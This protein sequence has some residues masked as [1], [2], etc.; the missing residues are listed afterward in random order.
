[1]TLQNNQGYRR[2]LNLRETPND[3]VALS[4]LGGAGIGEDLSRLQ[5][6]LRNTSK[7]SFHNIEEGYFSFGDDINV[8]ISSLRCLQSIRTSSTGAVENVTTITVHSSRSYLLRIGDLIKIE[9]VTGTGKITDGEGNLTETDTT[10]GVDI[11]KG[12]FSIT[13]INRDENQF[14]C[15]KAGF[16][17]S[18][19]DQ[20]VSGSNLIIRGRDVFAYT[21]DDTISFDKDVRV[22]VTQGTG[23]PPTII[24]DVTFTKGTP[25][26]V[27]DSNGLD[28]FKLSIRP[29]FDALGISTVV[30]KHGGSD[31][32]YTGLTTSFSLSEDFSM[33][34]S[35]PVEQSNLI[36]FIAPDIQ[37]EGF[38]Y[39]SGT[40][41]E[42]MDSVQTSNETSQYFI[43][44]K[45]KGSSGTTS[46]DQIKTEGSIVLRDP[47][48]DMTS[49]NVVTSYST[50]AGMFIEGTR[51]FSTDNNP[52]SD[53][54]SNTTPNSLE[55][56]SDEVTIGE[57][58]FGNPD[59]PPTITGP[60]FN[61]T[62]APDTLT[63]VRSLTAGTVVPT[64]FSHKIPVKIENPDGNIET[65]YLLLTRNTDNTS[66]LP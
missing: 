31:S 37:D 24:S 48:Q 65:Y 5:N 56:E 41:T 23:F 40:I 47:K 49:S 25:Y 7:M 13:R 34:R 27:C 29:S 22:Y 33:I 16:S 51:A 4:N 55:T 61:G 58:Y 59:V 42:Q 26:Y 19:R 44:K 20:N 39:G 14:D 21:N 15:I 32:G 1:M 54:A 64:D 17:T 63:G 38:S 43:G 12:D 28:R 18:I 30:I 45:Y 60:G 36:N 50:G 8:G 66:T 52:W 35:E 10:V 3:R 57:L 46:T 9:N 2:D 6:N 53:K 62:H 11:F